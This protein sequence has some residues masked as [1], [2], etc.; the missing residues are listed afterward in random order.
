LEVLLMLLFLKKLLGWFLKIP[1]L[2]A[3]FPGPTVMLVIIA[4]IATAAASS[5]VTHNL[6]AGARAALEI[7]LA[8]CETGHQTAVAGAERVRAD[9]IEEGAR[10]QAVYDA[11]NREA[12]LAMVRALADVR[13]DK[14][15]LAALQKSVEDLHRDPNFA[16]RRLPLPERHLERV[17]IPEARPHPAEARGH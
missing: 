8:K 3:H 11:E 13:G 4:G 6:E 2:F 15:A 1:V 10:R 17:R 7:K 16:C 5:C 12:W 9:T 14:T